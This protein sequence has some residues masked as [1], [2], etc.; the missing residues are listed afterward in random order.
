MKGRR[1]VG[2]LMMKNASHSIC[3]RKIVTKLP[4]NERKIYAIRK[5]I[6]P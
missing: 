4:N 3:E 6:V 5:K 2:A 1:I